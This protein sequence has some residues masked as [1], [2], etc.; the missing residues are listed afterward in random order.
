[1]PVTKHGADDALPSPAWH[2]S[3]MVGT[4]PPCRLR[5]W[6]QQALDAVKRPDGRWDYTPVGNRLWAEHAATLTAEARAH[7][8]APYWVRKQT[9]RGDGFTRWQQQFLT[10]HRY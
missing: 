6:V 9:P 8:F 5:G 3:L 4:P 1:M 10:E 2:F 7:G